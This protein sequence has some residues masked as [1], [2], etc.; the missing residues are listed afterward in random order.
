MV[1][2]LNKT[3]YQSM[4]M[5]ESLNLTNML[6]MVVSLKTSTQNNRNHYHLKT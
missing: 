5:T 3:L 4:L 2:L 6:R 1:K